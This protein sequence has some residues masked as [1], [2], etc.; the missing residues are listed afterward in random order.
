[1]TATQGKRETAAAKA[2]IVL[3]SG[4]T[5][6]HVFPAQALSAEL[7]A[8][9]HSVS[10]VTDRRG[11]NFPGDLD[12]HPISAGTLG[13][14]ARTLA[15]GTMENAVGLGQSL[16][17]LRRLR[18]SVV[19]GFG[20]YPSLPPMIAAR[21]LRIPT[22]LH[23]Q[24]AV[25]GR[26]N[27]ILAR[28]VT[29]I[30]T[31]FETVSGILP[32]DRAKVCRTGNPVRPAVAALAGAPFTVPGPE[33]PLEIFVLG[34]SQGAHV[35]SE[36]IPAAV[37]LLPEQYR[38]R[39]RIAQ[40]CRPEDL[41]EVRAAYATLGVQVE[42]AAFFRDVPQRLVAAHLVIAR[43]GASTIAE[44]TA[45]GRPAIL[46]PYPFAMDDHQAANAHAIDEAGGAW[47]MPQRGFCASA[48]AA[49][50]ES[51][52]TL[53][54]LLEPVAAASRNLGLPQAASRLADL[55]E[56]TAEEYAPRESRAAHD[57]RGLAA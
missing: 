5:G 36:V 15:R 27:R 21:L 48:L 51:V 1:M 7:V 55:V 12:V 56:E 38:A 19:V 23:E 24:N 6:G 2:R 49:R 45:I 17:L 52:L 4:G 20:G 40:Q 18:P 10:V 54:S 14:S 22:V 25:L 39:L 8:R 11:A 3:A 46:V 43:S 28:R 30:A 37:A 34:G 53:P 26:A 44:I 33:G 29:R 35:F 9:G 42:L 16:R 13:R 31:S 50:L 47:L 41:E 57:L 32:V